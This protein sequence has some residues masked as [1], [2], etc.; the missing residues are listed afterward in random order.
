MDQNHSYFFSVWI[1]SF[2]KVYL[3][4]QLKTNCLRTASL[5]KNKKLI[6]NAH[7]CSLIGDNQWNIIY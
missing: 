2:V 6:K 3:N 1:V 4:K 5:I 7:F